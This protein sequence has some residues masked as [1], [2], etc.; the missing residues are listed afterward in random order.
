MQGELLL[1]TY[2]GV[3]DGRPWDGELVG[4]LG[5]RGIAARPVPWDRAGTDW[6]GV[7]LRNTWDYPA[8]WPEFLAWMERLDREGV[9]MWNPLPIVRWNAHKSYLRDLG[10]KGIPIPP[11][12]W[13]R[14]GSSDTLSSRL[15]SAGWEE[16][17][18]KPAISADAR[19]TRRIRLDDAASHEAWFRNLVATRDALIQ[20]FLPAVLGGEWAFVFVAG[21]FSHAVLKR[22]RSGDWRVQP[23]LG[24]TA[25]LVE[26]ASH[27]LEFA[28]RVAA[29]VPDCLYARVDAVWADGKGLLMELELIEPYLYLDLAPEGAARLAAAIQNLWP[30]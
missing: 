19:D 20:P 16:A 29:A 9:P 17:V 14:A 13:V 11:T 30:G 24:G 5:R 1:A 3:P 6:S 2:D 10:R 27:Q 22:P 12:S 21:A 25:N 8:R 26:P 4:E 15:A 18:V 23:R 28:E 7:V